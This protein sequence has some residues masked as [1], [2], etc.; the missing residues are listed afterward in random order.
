MDQPPYQQPNTNYPQGY[1][2]PNY[3]Q[4]PKKKGKGLMI[5]LIILGSVFV[6]CATCGIIAAVASVTTSNTGTLTSSTPGTTSTT[7]PTNQHFKPGDTVIV[8]NTWQIVVS[9]L[10]I[11]QGDQY[12]SPKAGDTYL[13]IPVT[14]K[15]VTDKEQQLYGDANWT[16]KD[17][18]GQKYDPAFIS[19][20]S[21]PDGKIEA[22]GPAKGT[23]AYEVPANVKS[24]QLAF[25]I[26]MFESG[27]TIWD[28]S[29]S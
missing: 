6:L 5:A 13:L 8:G 17:L 19:A 26:S 29:V 24:F 12:L 16:L 22:G 25:E 7:A 3:Q 21:P 15:N 14:F 10:A 23:L 2:Q 4:P 20:A 9:T 27:Q 11:S 1:P 18:S 28:L